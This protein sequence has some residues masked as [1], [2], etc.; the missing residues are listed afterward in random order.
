MLVVT[1]PVEYH[2]A[3]VLGLMIAGF[4]IERHAV[5]ESPR[6]CLDSLNSYIDCNMSL[7]LWIDQDHWI[8]SAI[9]SMSS[10]FCLPEFRPI[11]ADG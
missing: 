4:P 9:D 2:P 7:F 1:R 8:P 10:C 3:A 6:R 11:K 5:E